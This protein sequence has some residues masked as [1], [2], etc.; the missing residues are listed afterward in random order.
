MFVV[1]WWWWWW[2]LNA[3]LE[4]SGLARFTPTGPKYKITISVNSA[5]A[6]REEVDVVAGVEGEVEGGGNRG[7]T[8]FSIRQIL[9]PNCPLGGNHSP[10]KVKM[11][12][13]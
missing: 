1:M 13:K 6:S 11:I 7:G 10:S 8:S 9:K 3:E 4:V 5:D 12:L 2:C